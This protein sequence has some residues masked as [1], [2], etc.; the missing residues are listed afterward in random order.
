MDLL[1][2]PIGGGSSAP[3]TLP[4]ATA[5]ALGGVKV[6]SGLAIDGDGVLSASGG[7]GGGTGL[8][9]TALKT[10]A[11]TATSGDLVICDS[12]AG[13]F[14]VTL[15]AAPAA[16]ATVGIIDA[17][18]SAASYPITVGR[19]GATIRG[20]AQDVTVDTAW[21]YTEWVYS[22]STWALKDTPQGATGAVRQS[23]LVYLAANASYAGSGGAD[24]AVTGWTVAHDDTGLWNA[25]SQCFQVPAGASRIRLTAN[26]YAASG[27]SLPFGAAFEKNATYNSSTKALTAIPLYAGRVGAYM[28]AANVV[29]SMASAPLAVTAGD[30]FHLAF[31]SVGGA[32]TATAL[33]AAQGWATWWGAEILA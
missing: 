21:A 10:S 33:G 12:S 28:T 5:E 32:A 30:K 20:Q 29:H 1:P 22:G 2:R 26:I 4:A 18:G 8:T 14:A 16:G 15:P 7:G 24:G 27:S 9:A 31:N 25:T 17:T 11:Y 23:A 3:Y 6:G 19:N 13:A